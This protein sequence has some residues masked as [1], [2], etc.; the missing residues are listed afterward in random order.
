MD[1]ANIDA[2]FAKNGLCKSGEW[3]DVLNEPF[4]IHGVYFDKEENRFVRLPYSV[5]ST[6]NPGVSNLYKQTAGGRVRFKTTSSSIS[7]KYTIEKTTTRKVAPSCARGFS[8]YENGI[9]RGIVYPIIGDFGDKDVIE[10]TDSVKLIEEGLKD[11]EIYFPLYSNVQN[12]S[13]A[14][15][16]NSQ[17]FKP[18][19]YL[20]K[21]ILYY[22]S[23]IT[24]GGC[25]SRPGND[26][27]AY[28]QRWT[29][30]DYINLGFAGNAKGE[31]EMAEYIVTRK[32]DIVVMDY[33]YN[34]PSAEHLKDT[35]FAFYQILRKG[36][37]NTPIIMMSRPNYSSLIKDDEARRKVVKASYNKAKKDGDSLVS[38]VDGRYLFGKDERESCTLD[39]THPNDLGFYRMA[40]KLYPTIKK[41][42]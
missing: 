12:L 30:T 26:Y 9:F 17:I 11:I 28:I 8:V 7:F 38:F 27:Q 18:E 6:V 19:E 10:Y 34:A 5:A 1:I 21:T 35:H 37:P 3:I 33:D 23:S 16:E 20:N 4:S 32:P 13:L 14:F 39:G 42:L 15:S 2:N 31:K 25:A 29:N 41:Y 24:Q 40:R 36:L 22:G